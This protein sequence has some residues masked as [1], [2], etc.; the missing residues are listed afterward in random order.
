MDREASCGG[1]LLGLHFLGELMLKLTCFLSRN[2]SKAW[3]SVITLA[4]PPGL[5]KR[6]DLNAIADPAFFVPESSGTKLEVGWTI[7]SRLHRV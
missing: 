5:T 4:I 1:S 6:L 2:C 3:R 7:L